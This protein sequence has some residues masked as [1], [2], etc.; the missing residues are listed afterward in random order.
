MGNTEN[1]Q[2]NTRDGLKT[3]YTFGLDATEQFLIQCRTMEYTDGS[4][5]EYKYNL[6]K[7]EFE[8][9][10]VEPDGRKSVS[11]INSHTGRSYTTVFECDGS[12]SGQPINEEDIQEILVQWRKLILSP[13]IAFQTSEV[14]LRG[15]KVL[16]QP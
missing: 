3:V 16:P 14:Y 6:T 13:G 2:F 10:L 8:T 12:S 15:L 7:A 5:A 1:W 11:I 9:T 4:Q